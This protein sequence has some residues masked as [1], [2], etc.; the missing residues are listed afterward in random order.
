MR[1]TDR[2]ETSQDARAVSSVDIMLE[3]EVET[4][5]KGLISPIWTPMLLQD[6]DTEPGQH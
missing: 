2:E 1:L 3:D 5:S 6:G 4:K